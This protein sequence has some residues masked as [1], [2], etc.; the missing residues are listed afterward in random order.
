[1]LWRPVISSSEETMWWQPKSWRMTG[2]ELRIWQFLKQN[3]SKSAWSINFLIHIWSVWS[4]LITCI[5]LFFAVAHVVTRQIS[6]LLVQRDLLW[7]FKVLHELVQS[8]ALV[9]ASTAFVEPRDVGWAMVATAQHRGETSALKHL[10]RWCRTNRIFVM[11]CW[12]VKPRECCYF[13]FFHKH[14]SIKLTFQQNHGVGSVLAQNHRFWTDFSFGPTLAPSDLRFC[15]RRLL[16]LGHGCT[17]KPGLPRPIVASHPKS[18]CF[19][20]NKNW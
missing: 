10:K 4:H 1:M 12:H 2:L 6:P 15:I 8:P 5:P 11:R 14:V 18:T 13:M 16:L 17:N 20:Y 9:A 19:F 7:H 3:P